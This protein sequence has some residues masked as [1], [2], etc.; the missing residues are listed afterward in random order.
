MTLMDK[1]LESLECAVRRNAPI[2][3]NLQWAEPMPLQHVNDGSYGRLMPKCERISQCIIT[4]KEC[5]NSNVLAKIKNSIP[6]GVGFRVEDGV[7]GAYRFS[8]TLPCASNQTNQANGETVMSLV[9]LVEDIIKNN[10]DENHRRSTLKALLE[11]VQSDAINIDQ[12]NLVIARLASLEKTTNII[13][14]AMTK[15]KSQVD[16]LETKLDELKTQ[17]SGKNPLQ[18]GRRITRV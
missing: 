1:M 18:K 16:S 9:D 8:Q 7:T 6:L 4:I 13:E 5:S 15:S 2:T 11:S 14:E 10:P 17:I 12:W 3:V